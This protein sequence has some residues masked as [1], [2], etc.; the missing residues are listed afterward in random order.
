[1]TLQL[2][3]LMREPNLLFIMEA[4]NALS[5]K[6]AEAAGF[7]ALWASGLSISASLGLRDANEASWTQV[8]DI[9]EHMA[10]A[11]NRPILLDGDTGFGN[12]NNV[13][14]LVRKL[15]ERGLAGVCLEDKTFPKMNSF[16]EDSQTLVST[17]EFVGKIRAAKDSQQSSQFFVV[18]RTEGFIAG[19]NV[20]E[21]LARAESYAAAGADAIL[22][23][24]KRRDS[25]EIEQF[26]DGWSRSTPVVIVPTTYYRSDID[27]LRSKGVSAVIWANHNLRSSVRAMQETCRRVMATSSVTEIEGSIASLE[28]IFALVDTEELLSAE[29]KYLPG[30]SAIS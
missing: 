17:E 3:E 11:V 18:A 21:V 24:S 26:L 22:V 4:H 16:I 23:H 10:D 1:M 19:R 20:D 7:K 14:R 15:C 29:R 9:A 6:I 5:A 12:F 28:D 2:K 25:V 13:R 30:R 8:L 27:Q